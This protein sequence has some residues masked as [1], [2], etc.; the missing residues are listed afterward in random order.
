MLA[1]IRAFVYFAIPTFSAACAGNSALGTFN[2]KIQ[3]AYYAVMLTCIG[4]GVL[5]LIAAG[6]PRQWRRRFYSASGIVLDVVAIAGIIVALTHGRQLGLVLGA[7]AITSR[8][9]TVW[10]VSRDRPVHRIFEN[11]G[12]GF[13]R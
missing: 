8:L 13:L 11:D 4:C 7:I 5:M 12:Q 10:L 6:R 3:L 9:V 2:I 1:Q